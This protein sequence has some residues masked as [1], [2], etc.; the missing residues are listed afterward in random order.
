MLDDRLD[1]STI[2]ERLRGGRYTPTDATL[3]RLSRSARVDRTPAR[4]DFWRSR[5]ALVLT[6]VFGIGLSTTGGALA[7]SGVSSSNDAAT[8]QYGNG[9]QG[10][11]AGSGGSPGGRETLSEDTTG[12]GSESA[13]DVTQASGQTGATGSGGGLPFTGYL[14][15][16]LVA[17]GL[18]LL[19]SGLTLRRRALRED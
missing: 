17:A 12:A 11:N 15:I 5:L 16:P 2:E 13:G 3:D 14:A 4:A 9:V 18:V 1:P 19:G 8:A 10:T 6:L 7:V